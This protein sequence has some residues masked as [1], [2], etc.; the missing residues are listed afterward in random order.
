MDA[1]KTLE[2]LTKRKLDN[3]TN[4]Y[5]IINEI[6]SDYSRMTDYKDFQAQNEDL[7]NKLIEIMENNGI[8]KN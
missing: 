1:S 2:N 7:K 5:G 3:L 8:E 4:L 6:C